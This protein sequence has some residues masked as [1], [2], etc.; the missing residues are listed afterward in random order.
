MALGVSAIQA[1]ILLFARTRVRF[2]LLPSI[3]CLCRNALDKLKKVIQDTSTMNVAQNILSQIKALDPMALPAW[4]AKD[5]INMGDGLKFK[6]TGMT[7]YKGYVYV[8]Y[9]A[10]KDL[11]DVQ[12][13]KLRKLE[14]KMDKVVED[15]Y[16]E[17]LVRVID[18]F[19]G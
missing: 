1:E 7:P 14:V 4:G 2:G 15:V 19:V 11:Y 13:F 12:F 5:L 10:G 17:D 6:T 18:G 3:G 8:K 16:A 9:N